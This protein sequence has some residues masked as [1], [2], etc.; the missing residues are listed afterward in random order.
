MSA[1]YVIAF[2]T[3]ASLQIGTGHVMRCLTLADALRAKGAQC[4]FIS[5]AHPGH[6]MDVIRQRGYR[7]KSLVAPVQQA[8]AAIKNIASRSQETQQYMPLEPAH[9]AWLGTTWQADAQET[10][11]VLTSLQPDWLVVDHYALDQRWEAA[12]QTQSK[13]LMVIDDLAD[14]EHMCDVLL[15][16]NLVEFMAA[17]YQGKVPAHCTCLLGPQYALVRPEFSALRPVSLARRQLP[18]LNRLLV[19]M[20]GSDTTN[21]TGKV[22]AGIQLSNKTW[23]HIDVVV[24][25]SH[26][27]LESLKERLLTLPFAKLHVQTPHMAKLMAD[28]DLA[29]TTG[30]SITWEKCTL[31]VPSLVVIDGDNQ[32][33]IATMMHARGAQRT[34]GSASDITPAM[35]A[36]QLNKL[37][38]NELTAM[39]E[40]ASAICNGTGISSVVK[41]IE[42]KT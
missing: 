39:S 7:V 3:D 8:Q 1:A 6:L 22:I 14:R 34:M 32:H 40:C 42:A 27:A 5:R 17:R 25:Q 24:G 26:P 15:D 37:R 10:A 36:D 29:I 11:T 21:E 33:P 41:T 4:H 9:A 20:G 12:L 30:G 2:R 23:Q 31:G 18:S 13:K 38:V 35:Y 28:A 16:Q 19:F